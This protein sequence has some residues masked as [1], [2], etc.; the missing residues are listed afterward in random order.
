MK[1]LVLPH[2]SGLVYSLMSRFWKDTMTPEL[3]CAF[4]SG[5]T[6][7][8]QSSNVCNSDGYI[9]L[10]ALLGRTAEVGCY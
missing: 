7:S 2:G 1:T 3:A 8:S 5:H 6:G 10:K 4:C 9:K